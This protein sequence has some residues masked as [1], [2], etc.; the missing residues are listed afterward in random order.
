MKTEIKQILTLIND[1]GYEAY[2]IGGYVRDNY[3]GIN[4]LDIDIC[5]SAKYEALKKIFPNLKYID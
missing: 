5:T 2:V 1:N 4:S 3:L